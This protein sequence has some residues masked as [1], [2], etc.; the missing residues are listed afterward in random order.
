IISSS[1]SDLEPIFEAILANAT[2]LCEASYGAMFLCEGDT[3]R[4]VALHGALPASFAAELRR[5]A[6]FRPHP[7]VPVARATRTR[8]T[9]HV[10]D[11]RAEQAYLALCAL[12]RLHHRSRR[13][14]DRLQPRSGNMGIQ[15]RIDQGRRFSLV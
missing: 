11:L 7:G 15:P 14:G 8:Q 1:P 13:K 6:V 4:N 9:V 10:A 3:F 2:R 12:A 5:M